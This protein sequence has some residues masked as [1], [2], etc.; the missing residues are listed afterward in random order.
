M[1]V[2]KNRLHAFITGHSN[3]GVTRIARVFNSWGH[4]QFLLLILSI[5]TPSEITFNQKR[6][7]QL[8]IAVVFVALL[9]TIMFSGSVASAETAPV[10]SRDIEAVF[11]TAVE[12]RPPAAIVIASTS[13]LVTL[14]FDSESELK[15]GSSAGVV[16]DVIEGDRVISTAVFDP[17]GKLVALK[18]IIRVANSQPITKHVVGVVTSVTEDELSI[19]TRNGDVVNVLIPAGIDALAVGDGITMVARLDRSSGVLTAV[20]FELARATVERIQNARDHAANQVELA[21]LS[22]IATDARSKHLSALDDASRALKRVIDSGRVDKVTLNKATEQFN[23]IQRRFNQLRGIYESAARERNE[24]QPLLKI[25]G[26][27]VDEIGSSRFTIVPKGE[28]DADPFS[29]EFVFDPDSTEVEL[30]RDLLVE[31]SA[32]AKNPQLLSDVRDLIVPGSELDVKYSVDEGVRNAALIRVR[33]PKLVEELETVLEHESK[34]AFHGVITL[35]EIDDSLEDALGIVIAAN[36]KQGGKVAAKVTDE[37][38]MTVDGESS[39]IS[40]L[41]AGQAVDIQFESSAEGSISDITGSDVTLRALAIRARSS[42]PVLEDHISGIVESIEIDV[43]A[44]TIRPTDGSLIRLT[45]GEDVPIIRSGKRVEFEAVQV[46]DL[47]IDAVRVNTDSNS[48]TRLVVVAKSN[49][50]FRGTVTGIGRE[51]NRLLVT[52]ENGQS[53][54]TLVT[55]ETKFIVD[56]RG[57]E[58]GAVKTGMKIINGVYTVT[59]HG[60]AFYNVATIVSIESPKVVRATGIITFVNAADGE[61]TVLSGKS[62]NTRSIELKLPELPLGENLLKD[63]LPIESLSEVHRGDRVDIVF[64]VLG[65]GIIEKLSVVSDNF[66]QARGALLSVS[67]NNRIA[68]VE[69]ANGTVFDLWVGAGSEMRLHGRRI[70]TLRPV[71]ELLNQ[72]KNAGAEISALVPGVMFIKDSIDSDRGVIITIQFQIKVESS[73]IDG[74]NAVELTVSGPIEAIKGNTW[75][76]DGRVFTVVTGTRFAGEKPEAGLVA[77]AVL[78]SKPDGTFIAKTISVSGRPR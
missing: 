54:N 23:E 1:N 73:R 6:R 17:E 30:P 42:A 63:G 51:P 12:I 16:A 28:Q 33:L 36:E 62:T 44:I 61:L 56:G 59:G 78:V 60:G 19:Q 38:E 45:V 37:T 70:A 9:M 2:L 48:L 18:T 39:D 64:Y 57:V 10:D 5:M 25:S 24:A 20:G 74:A 69:L 65:S 3:K 75:V 53:L 7:P 43:P 50:K 27:L 13:G 49:V 72:A 26:A 11:G 32:S 4:S 31:V 35:V 41:R 55:S 67:S 52:G 47:V 77:V 14:N 21:R 8:A 46:G 15:I 29:V 22:Q 68:T 34:R 40:S 71:G 58:F 66:I 76:V